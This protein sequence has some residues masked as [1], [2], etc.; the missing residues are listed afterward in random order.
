MSKSTILTAALIGFAL[1]GGAMAQATGQAMGPAHVADTAKG[2]AL[3]D[4][5]GMTLYTFDKDTDGKSACNGTCA[6]NWPAFT[7]TSATTPAG[8][9]TI[10]RE[11]GMKQWAYKGKP[12]YTFAK[13]E[14]PAEAKGDGLLN[15]A[16]H[17][18]MP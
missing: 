7:A 2:K 3:V 10:T 9:T 1:T 16:W 14:K 4:A 6:T 18:A 15:G 13:D 11:D 17:I 8:W 12:L 5:K